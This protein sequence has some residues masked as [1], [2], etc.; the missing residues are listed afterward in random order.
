MKIRFIATVLCSVMFT[1]CWLFKKEQGGRGEGK[2]PGEVEQPEEIPFG[3]VIPGR[4]GYVLSPYHNKV[5]D[6]Q[7]IKSGT[8]VFD[9]YDM[10]G[11]KRKF[12]VP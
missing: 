1:S 2:P 4:E 3:K 11:K 6:V 10:E 12:R 7:G 8:L 9:P 5:V